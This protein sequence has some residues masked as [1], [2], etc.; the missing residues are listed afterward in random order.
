MDQVKIGKF[1]SKNRKKKNITQQQLAEKLG[2]SDRTVGNWENGRNMPD[3]SLFKPLCDE[4]D[5]SINDLISGEKIKE[6]DYK[7]KLEENIINTI[8]Y[9]NN[10]TEKNNKKTSIILFIVGLLLISLILIFTK[11]CNI[12]LLILFVIGI[13]LIF[14]GIINFIKIK[15]NIKKVIISLISFTSLILLILSLDLFG[16]L[17]NKRKPIFIVEKE[18]SDNIL[19]YKSFF[20]NAYIINYDTNN[21]YYILDFKKEYSKDTVPLSPFDR[22]RAGI[23]NIIKYRS[24]NIDT[25]NIKGLLNCLPLFNYIDS[26]KIDKLT[27]ELIIDYKKV[28]DIDPF[29]I[30]KSLVYNSVSIFSLIEN[31]D[32]ITYNIMGQSLRISREDLVE[33]YS[34]FIYIHTN[35]DSKK[36][37]SKYFNM[38][39]ESD[40]N[41]ET[42]ASYY[43]KSLFIDSRLKDTKKIVLVTNDNKK[44]IT[45]GNII[46]SILSK[47]TFS[48]RLP[49][50]SVTDLMGS[51]LKIYFYD[52]DD[53][54]LLNFDLIRNEFIF[55]KMDYIYHDISDNSSIIDYDS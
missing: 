38:F 17:I 5:I 47:I 37:Y 42:L 21:E 7:D 48:V 41:N 3:L 53:R 15:S 35:I 36:Y 45:D 51:N 14:I 25:D 18:I 12:F 55:A 20:Y 19:I 54:L 6:K 4:L 49:R 29:Y 39:L 26:F 32:Y 8:N 9:S 46:E 50:N 52:K 27:K 23:D 13:I 34:S 28:I 30:E 11:S 44:I 16:V 22:D 33:V 1:I 2:V 31:L 43:F 24:K 10:V 40:M